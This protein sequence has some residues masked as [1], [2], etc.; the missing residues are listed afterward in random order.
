MTENQVRLRVVARMKDNEGVVHETKNA[1]KGVL[2]TS[3]G[4]MT[5]SYDDVQDSVKAKVLLSA[6]AK[7]AQMRRMGEMT[8]MLNFEPGKRT[9]GLYATMYGEIPV[10]VYTRTVKLEQQENG[11]EL[12][13]DYDVFVGGEKTSSADMTITWRV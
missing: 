13:L 3:A 7:G 11:G 8:G 10:A 5:L 9:S 6:D 2:K 12:K 4:S 1:R